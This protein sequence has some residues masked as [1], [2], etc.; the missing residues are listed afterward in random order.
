[1]VPICPESGFDKIRDYAKELTERA[2]EE[3]PD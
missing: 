1:M 2:V 3:A